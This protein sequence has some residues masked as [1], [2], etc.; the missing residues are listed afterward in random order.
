MAITVYLGILPQ[1]TS[2]ACKAVYSRIQDNE[3]MNNCEVYIKEIFEERKR[4]AI[5]V[6]GGENRQVKRK[7]SIITCS[8]HITII[9]KMAK[10]VVFLEA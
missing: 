9:L 6:V 2:C 3:A 8:V 1:C 10:C 4:S 7:P 5:R